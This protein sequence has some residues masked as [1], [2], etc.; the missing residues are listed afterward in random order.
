MKRLLLFLVIVISV[1]CGGNYVTSNNESR[2]Y[3]HTDVH[4]VTTFWANGDCYV[5]IYFKS[6]AKLYVGKVDEQTCAER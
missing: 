5:D 1:A 6:G 2:V 4:L 3:R